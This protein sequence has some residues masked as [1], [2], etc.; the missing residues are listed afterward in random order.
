MQHD[1]SFKYF[2]N[3]DSCS[4]YNCNG[5]HGNDDD[6]DNDSDDADDDDDNNVS[7]DD[8]KRVDSCWKFYRGCQHL[9]DMLPKGLR[10]C[11]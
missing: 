1:L 2:G 3:D 5:G 4:R 6:D 9:H 7:D 11:I 10:I 8:V